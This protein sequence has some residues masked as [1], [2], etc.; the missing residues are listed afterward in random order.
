MTALGFLVLAAAGALVRWQVVARSGGAGTLLIN[1]AGA[2]ALGILAGQGDAMMTAAG[3]G[4]L[5]SLTTVSGI[6][7]HVSTIT[8]HR[9]AAYAYVTLT[10]LL[11]VGAAY[12]GL[13]LA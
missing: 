5:G 1:V 4:G 11:G 3:T 13:L 10:L 7:G 9:V 8:R 12:A 6:V 2:F